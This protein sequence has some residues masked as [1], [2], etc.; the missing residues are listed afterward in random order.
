MTRSTEQLIAEGRANMPDEIREMAELGALFVLNHSAGKDSQCMAIYLKEL[1]ISPEQ[2][3]V[4]HADLGE[5]EWAGNLDHIRQTV[6]NIE[7]ITAEAKTSFFEM[8]ERRQMF[9]SPSQRQCT[10]DLK[11]GPLEREIRRYLK[12]H[13]EFRGLIVNCMGMRAQESASRAKK[14]EVQ[15]S[16]RNSKARRHWYDWL[17]IHGMTTDE[18]FQMIADAGQEP[19]YAYQLGMTRLSCCFCIMASVNDLTIAAQ[20]NPELYARYV[21]TERRIGH[22]LSM[23]RKPLEE[24]T[25]ILAAA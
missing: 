1:G 5:V 9:P 6:G 10:S 3:L 19:H 15:F 24:I 14:A 8:V 2:M 4:I 12:A 23:S 21:A 22:T 20:A 18:V 25:G 17:P 7:I 11:R 13:P 16:H